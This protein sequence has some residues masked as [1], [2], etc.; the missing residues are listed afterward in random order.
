MKLSTFFYALGGFFFVVA[1]LLFIEA[2]A[3]AEIAIEGNLFR[4]RTE[5]VTE[6][7]EGD[8]STYFGFAYPNANRQPTEKW[9]ITNLIHK[10]FLVDHDE[11]ETVISEKLISSTTNGYR[12]QQNWIPDPD[13]KPNSLP[14]TAPIV[15]P[16]LLTIT[17]GQWG[18]TNIFQHRAVTTNLTFPE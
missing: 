2:C 4:T 12:L 7:R 13:V 6:V 16:Y 11:R 3:G 18:F 15:T 9:V 5:V 17:N 14:F 10:T 8:S 1:F